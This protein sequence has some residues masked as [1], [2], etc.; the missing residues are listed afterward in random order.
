MGRTAIRRIPRA[1]IRDDLSMRSWKLQPIHLPDGDERDLWTDSGRFTATPVDGAAPLPGRFALPGLV[2]A[3]AHLALRAVDGDDEAGGA[4][5]VLDGQP[6]QGRGRRQA[7]LRLHR[8]PAGAAALDRRT[9]RR[10]RKDIDEAQV[11]SWM[12]QAAAIPG[13]GKR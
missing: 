9:D 7:D 5:D 1:S 4:E 6:R 12:T 13:F 3:H 2:D 10:P 8:Q 11:A